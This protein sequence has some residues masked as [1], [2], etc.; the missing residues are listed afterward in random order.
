MGFT[1]DMATWYE[2]P[3][4]LSDTRNVSVVVEHRAALERPQSGLQGRLTRF[5][6]LILMW[7]SER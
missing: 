3:L 2:S 7:A 1:T 6:A 5:T 4:Q